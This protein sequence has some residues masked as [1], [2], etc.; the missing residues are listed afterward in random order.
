MFKLS[1]VGNLIDQPGAVM[2][3]SNDNEYATLSELASAVRGHVE[4]LGLKPE[5][6]QANAIDF[7]GDASDQDRA[8]AANPNWWAVSG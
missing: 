2:T 7:D 1:I 5:S 6:V 3:F 4:R 8:A